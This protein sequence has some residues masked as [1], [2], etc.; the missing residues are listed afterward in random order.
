MLLNKLYKR[1]TQLSEP[2]E[3]FVLKVVFNQR[4]NA[5]VAFRSEQGYTKIVRFHDKSWV[6][7]LKIS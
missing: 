7:E 5:Q 1:K 3:C 2:S 4:V 6:R